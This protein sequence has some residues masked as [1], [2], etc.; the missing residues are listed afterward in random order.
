MS[1]SK[2]YQKV[3]FSIEQYRNNQELKRLRENFAVAAGIYVE[4]ITQI[5]R[6][7]VAYT[8][9]VG[10]DNIFELLKQEKVVAAQVASGAVFI[11]QT[12]GSKTI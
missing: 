9:P 2:L 6:D 5:K 4:L 3:Q 7:N 11:S 1:D 10:V 12:T 8:L